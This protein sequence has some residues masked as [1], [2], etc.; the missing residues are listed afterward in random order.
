MFVGVL[1]NLDPLSFRNA[2]WP[3][4]FE[5]LLK[6]PAKDLLLPL[7]LRMFGIWSIKSLTL[8]HQVIFLNFNEVKLVH[9]E[10]NPRM[11]VFGDEGESASRFLFLSAS[12]RAELQ[13]RVLSKFRSK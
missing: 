7:S 6:S 11:E 3:I 2:A 1:L 9:L 5:L 13:T 8:N 10:D 4:P 12:D